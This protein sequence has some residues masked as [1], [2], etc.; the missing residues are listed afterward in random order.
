MRCLLVNR[1]LFTFFGG[2]DTENL[3][4]H[5]DSFIDDGGFL[6]F[7]FELYY[8]GHVAGVIKSLFKL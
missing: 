7:K 8:T 2:E 6:S 4:R 1:R 5:S 3:V